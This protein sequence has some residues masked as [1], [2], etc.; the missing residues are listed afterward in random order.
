MLWAQ[1]GRAEGA[2]A[3]GIDDLLKSG[4]DEFIKKPFN[5]ALLQQRIETLLEL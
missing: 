1:S 4:A 2:G 5:I 3:S